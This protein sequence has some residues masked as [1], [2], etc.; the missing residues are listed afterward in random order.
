[1]TFDGT[2]NGDATDGKLTFAP[3]VA[4]YESNKYPPG[5]YTVTIKGTATES[6][7]SDTA[8]FSFTIE[9][10]CD[11]PNSINVIGAGL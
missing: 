4:D 7:K 2:F 5:V 1:M 6:G 9:D 11:P 3:T 8:T 10:P